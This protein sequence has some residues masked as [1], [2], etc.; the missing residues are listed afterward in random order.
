MFVT[1]M[2]VTKGKSDLMR[3][4]MIHPWQVLITVW[5]LLVPVGP[6]ITVFNVLL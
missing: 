1:E 6:Q 5:H 4:Y 2:F 3:C